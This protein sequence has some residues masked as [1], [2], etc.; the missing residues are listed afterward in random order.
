MVL[1]DVVGKR[2]LAE[3]SRAVLAAVLS[4]R[5][6][7]V[8]FL[9]HLQISRQHKGFGAEIAWVWLVVSLIV[10]LQFFSTAQLLL[11]DLANDFIFVHHHVSF[12]MVFWSHL[13]FANITTISWHIDPVE[14]RMA[15]E[16]SFVDETLVTVIA[17]KLQET[18]LE[19]L[20]RQKD[21]LAYRFISRVSCQV[22]QECLFTSKLLIA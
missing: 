19:E 13:S 12:E 17:L 16:Q 4:S 7:L 5:V 14:A 3:L 22:S 6:A 9:M 15:D 11:A 8:K 2:S 21:A 20:F 10:F 18:H 1:K